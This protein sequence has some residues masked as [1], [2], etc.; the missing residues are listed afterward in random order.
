VIYDAG[1]LVAAERS[2]PR[3]RALHHQWIAYEISPVIPSPVLAQV[4]RNGARQA[5]LARLLRGCRVLPTSEEISKHA[6]VLLGC[7]QTTDTI[8]AIVIA[9]AIA[10]HAVVV[11]SD[12]DDLRHLWNSA[13]TGFE[14]GLVMP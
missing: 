10:Y 6:G 11:T 7:S 13:D 8:D 2:E 4:W 9:T 3:I 5:R 12:P 1:A 14:I